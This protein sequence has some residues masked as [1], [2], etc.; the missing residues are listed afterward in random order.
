MNITESLE[1]NLVVK[2]DNDSIFI[3]ISKIQKEL[4][5]QSIK[6]ALIH[7]NKIYKE[8]ILNELL[9]FIDD[10]ENY[11]NVF[12]EADSDDIDLNE[13]F[14]VILKGSNKQVLES[15]YLNVCESNGEQQFYEVDFIVCSNTEFGKIVFKIE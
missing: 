5:N 15:M 2:V 11:S 10:S 12:L 3:D 1:L 6:E 4:L 13:D 14:K 7:I 9:K 8:T